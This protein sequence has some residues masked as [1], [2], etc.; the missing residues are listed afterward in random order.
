MLDVYKSQ[1]NYSMIG[2]KTNPLDSTA[3]KNRNGFDDLP[4]TQLFTDMDFAEEGEKYK[5]RKGGSH[6]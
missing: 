3:K 5:V 4:G 1:D 2:V 6:L